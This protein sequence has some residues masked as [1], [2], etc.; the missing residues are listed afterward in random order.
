MAWKPTTLLIEGMLDNTTPGKVTGWMKFAGMKEKVT[1]DLEGNFHRDIRGA[2]IR[3]IGGA[4]DNEPGTEGNMHGFAPHQTGKVDNITAGLS[5]ADYIFGSVSIE[6]YSQ[7]NGR[8][9]LE[10]EQDQIEFLSMPILVCESDPTSREEQNRNIAEF[11][12]SLTQEMNIP[13]ENAIYVGGDTVVKADK[14]VANNKIRGMKLLPCKI[15]ERLPRLGE[16]DCKGGKAVVYA[17]CFAPSSSLNWYISEGSPV[18][19]KDNNV[20]DYILYGF[21][22]GQC[23]ELGYFSLSEL[24][25]IRG[26]MGLPIERDL[27]WQPKTLEEIAPELFMPAKP[28]E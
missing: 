6:W 16:Q 17:K 26:P 15:R 27:Y 28:T 5:P 13:E 8:V 11:R 2:K 18:W 7:L 4:A 25:S 9:V 20:V 12:G 21:V 23:K 19:N 1:F 24:E 3:L 14:R 22:E 10:L